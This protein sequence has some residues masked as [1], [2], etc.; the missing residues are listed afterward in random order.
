MC[1]MKYS[2]DEI[3]NAILKYLNKNKPNR[4]WVFK[5]T[6]VSS[7]DHINYSIVGVDNERNEYPLISVNYLCG[8]E[9]TAKKT[10]IDTFILLNMNIFCDLNQ[11][12][13]KMELN[14]FL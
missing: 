7:C 5:N 3:I 12:I 4:T 2:K 14:G 11:F 9:H 13:M 1:S 8:E 6:C 10:M